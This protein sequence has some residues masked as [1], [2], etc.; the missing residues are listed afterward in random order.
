MARLRPTKA[1][2]TVALCHPPAWKGPPPG[3]PVPPSVPSHRSINRA[4]FHGPFSTLSLSFTYVPL[5]LPGLAWPGLAS[6]C[7][8]A[9]WVKRGWGSWLIIS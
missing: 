3:V 1:A 6:L 9:L 2:K 4:A 5:P 8:A 7:L